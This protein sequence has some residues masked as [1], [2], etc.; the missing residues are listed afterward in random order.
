M[1]GGAL[2]RSPA[3]IALAITGVAGRKPHDDHNPVGFVCIAA[4]REDCPSRHTEW[5][6]GPMGRAKI[7]DEAMVDALT[8]AL[9]LIHGLR[10]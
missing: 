1:A 10:N 2:R 7:S 8:K 3:N 6:Y 9:G 5:P 4:T